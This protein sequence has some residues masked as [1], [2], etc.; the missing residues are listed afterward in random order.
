MYSL[1]LLLSELLPQFI[2]M[3]TT[4]IDGNPEADAVQI[5]GNFDRHVSSKVP[6]FSGHSC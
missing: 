3:F 5:G 4:H 6:L 1:I 2:L